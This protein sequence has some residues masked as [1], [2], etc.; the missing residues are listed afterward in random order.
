MF[1]LALEWGFLEEGAPNPAKR[2]K[3]FAEEKRDRWI[4]PEELPRLAKAI[5]TE[6][7]IYVRSALWL[8][9]LTGAR[10][11]E[12]LQAKWDDID[13]ERKELRMAETKAGRVHYLPLSGEAL[14]LLRELPRLKGNPYILPGRRNG[15]PLVNIDKPWRRVRDRATVMFW[16]EYEGEVSHLI[17]ELTESLERAPTCHEVEQA[18]NFELSN[19]IRD[20]RLHDLRRTVGSWLAQAGNSLHLIGKVLNHSNQSTTAVYARFQQDTVRDALEQHGQRIMGAAKKKQ[21]AKVVNLMEI[22]K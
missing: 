7:N 13:W 22:N 2:I 3:K 5:D 8:Y 4:T 18:T 19:G 10:K 17:N 21:T 14:A 9:L 1:E 20:V 16:A 6:D 11:T 15:R 12:I